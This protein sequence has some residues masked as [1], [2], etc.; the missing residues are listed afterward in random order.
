MG[1]EY[2]KQRQQDRPRPAGMA[3]HSH[4]WELST[5][6]TWVV[7]LVKGFGSILHG[8]KQSMESGLRNDC[9]HAP[10]PGG[11]EF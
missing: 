11:D 6:W 8:F 5:T 3:R 9:L 1:K 7:A 2:A 10:V 4:S